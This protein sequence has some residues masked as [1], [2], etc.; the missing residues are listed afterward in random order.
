MTEIKV[1]K[2]A[3]VKCEHA[4]LKKDIFWC[5]SNCKDVLDHWYCEDFEGSEDD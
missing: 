1:N 4:V 5:E 2:K 3:C